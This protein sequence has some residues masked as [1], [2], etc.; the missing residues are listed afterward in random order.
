MSKRWVIER[1]FGWLM[2]HRRL[3]RDYE[4]LPERARAMIQIR[5]NVANRNGHP[6]PIRVN[7]DQ[8][9]SEQEPLRP[10]P[11]PRVFTGQ[12][13]GKRRKGSVDEPVDSLAAAVI[14]HLSDVPMLS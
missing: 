12:L 7:I 14:V 13:E 4:A 2:Q 5:T 11:A 1:T 9:L 6:A 10:D 8:I 3:A